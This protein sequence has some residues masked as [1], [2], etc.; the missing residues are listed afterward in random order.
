[1]AQSGEEVIPPNNTVYARNLNEKIPV[2]GTLII[3][4]FLNL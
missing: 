4:W 2:D 3:L 1:M